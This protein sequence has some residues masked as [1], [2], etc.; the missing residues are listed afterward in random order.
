M[1]PLRNGRQINFYQAGVATD[2]TKELVK[3]I[4]LAQ[5]LSAKGKTL[6]PNYKKPVIRR[7]YRHTPH[8]MYGTLNR[9]IRVNVKQPDGSFTQKLEKVKIALKK[10]LIKT[11]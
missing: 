5:G 4:N 2:K 8:K 3:E 11:A 9:P 7:A 1:L 6:N 10:G